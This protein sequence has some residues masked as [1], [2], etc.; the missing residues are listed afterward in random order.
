L[1]LP[2]GFGANLL[3]RV[4]TAVV[5]LPLLLAL[6]FLAPA[7]AFVTLAAGVLM[8]GMRELLALLAAAGTHPSRL[9][10]WVALGAFFVDVASPLA[11]APPLW[12]LGALAAGVAVLGGGDHRAALVGVAAAWLGAAYLGGLGGSIAALRVMP[13][14]QEGAWRV[15][16]LLASVMVADTAAFFV[17][18]ALGRR[19]LAPGLSPGKTVE[20]ALGG[21][22]G[23]ALGALAVQRLGM[24]WLPALHAAALGLGVAALGVCGDLVESR[25]KRAAGVKDSGGLFP[26]HGG[27]LDR[28][29]SLLLA[30]PVLYYYF[31]LATPLR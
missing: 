7:S 27:V 18:H 23:G 1:S 20:G 10:A 24:P 8:L 16:L 25:L 15:V 29:D 30:G 4:A 13:P 22:A 14:S 11:G 12:P 5:A 19:P 2:A 31:W 9:T 6:L 21:L 28:L 26:G 3:R 17:G